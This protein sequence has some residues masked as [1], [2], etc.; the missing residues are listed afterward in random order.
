MTKPRTLRH[1]ADCESSILGGILLRNEIL[2]SLDTLRTDDFYDRKHQVVFEAM[3]NLE[4]AE[5]PIDVVTVE[6]EIERAGKLDAIGG[7]AF[8]GELALRVPTV[9]NVVHY[10]R[11][12]QQLARVRRLTIAG[13]ELV[14]RSYDPDANPEELLAMANALLSKLDDA[15]PNES[16]SVGSFVKRRVRE[17]EQQWEARARGEVIWSGAPTGVKA[18]DK[19]I[20]GYPFGDVTIVAGRPGMGK[21]SF[22]MA[23]VDAT[24]TAGFGAHVFSPEGGWRMYAD[25]CLSRAAGISVEKLRS[26]DVEPGQT[27]DIGAAM[28]RYALRANWEL[29][30]TGGLSADEI[31]RRVRAKKKQLRTR[32]V[33][34]DYLNILRRDPR[35]NEN[36][37]LEEI[38]NT[39]GQAAPND[40]IAWVLLC[41]LNRD[42]EKRPDKRPNASDLRGSGALEQVARLIIGCYRGSYY[43]ADAKKGIDY[44][45]PPNAVCASEGES[46]SHAPTQEQFEQ[47]FQALLMKNNNGDT[48]RVFCS[49][50]SETTEIW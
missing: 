19:K 4:A 36:A 34:V 5:R 6:A 38:V 44:E 23:G 17:L 48:G 16:G 27:R 37:A 50:R 33:V 8:L 21:T 45:C 12:V 30:P 41:Q 18:L 32:M 14:E 24:T 9:D 22:V 29:D 3:R 28:M 47:T 35:L 7:V 31:V 20:G 26:G 1:N 42:V 40:D 2:H 11:E 43:Y 15:R 10:A 39:F 46:C 25:R 49:W 13:S